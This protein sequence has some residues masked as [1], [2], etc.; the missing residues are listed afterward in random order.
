MHLWGRWTDGQ[1]GDL[2]RSLNC[3]V[4]GLDSKSH[5]IWL[6]VR[7]LGVLHWFRVLLS[8]SVPFPDLNHPYHRRLV[9]RLL[10]RRDC[11]CNGRHLPPERWCGLAQTV[12][13]IWRLSL[14]TMESD[15]LMY[16]PPYHLLPQCLTATKREP[17][18]T[19]YNQIALV[20]VCWTIS[21]KRRRYD[22]D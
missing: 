11:S 8:G 13:R 3:P 2:R 19:T 10:C 1:V 5:H 18:R 12:D 14:S 7:Q 20:H 22:C 9:V 6:K 21:T 16:R 4:Q 15:T 17:Q